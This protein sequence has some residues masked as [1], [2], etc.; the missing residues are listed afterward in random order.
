MPK[1]VALLKGINVGG[2]KKIKM[3]ELKAL[4]ESMNLKNASTYI[5]SGNVIFEDSNSNPVELVQK[6]IQNSLLHFYL[7][8]QA[9]LQ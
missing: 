2:Q 3:D 1:Y 7:I 6:K 4:F 5:Q 8:F 9:V